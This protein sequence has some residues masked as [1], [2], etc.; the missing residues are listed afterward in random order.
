MILRDEADAIIDNLKSQLDALQ[1]QLSTQARGALLPKISKEEL[2]QKQ[3][4]KS[5][6]P[7]VA[8]RLGEQASQLADNLAKVAQTVPDIALQ[9]KIKG[10]QTQATQLNHALSGIESCYQ[11]LEERLS[12]KGS[13]VS[14]PALAEQLAAVIKAS[15]KNDVPIRTNNLPETLRLSPACLLTIISALAVLVQEMFKG[16]AEITLQPAHPSTPNTLE[17]ILIGLKPASQN[18]DV[19]TATLA[20][21]TPSKVLLDILYVDKILDMRGGSMGFTNDAK[22][23]WVRLPLS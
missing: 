23:I 3:W 8:G 11:V 6:T 2:Q 20:Q 4:Q 9:E 16:L 19:L 18:K 22:K 15:S 14:V 13:L 5:L 10:C 7:K 21:A 1:H 12:S 17:I